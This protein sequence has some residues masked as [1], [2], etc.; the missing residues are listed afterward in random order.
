MMTISD[1]TK[2]RRDG[3]APR[4][5]VPP[6][7]PCLLLRAS[8]L[9]FRPSLFLFGRQRGRTG[10]NANGSD[11]DTDGDDTQEP[12]RLTPATMVDCSASQGGRRPPPQP[13]APAA[14]PQTGTATQSPRDLEKE[15]RER[16]NAKFG[17]G[18]FEGAARCY[19]RYGVVCLW[20]DEWGDFTRAVPR[21]MQTAAFL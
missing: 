21:A 20:A 14:A 1:P 16:G 2:G 11:S 10:N 7:G 5:T 15:E 19:T 13:A 6:V 9:A 3:I 4:L 17:Q 18:D 8:P 12:P